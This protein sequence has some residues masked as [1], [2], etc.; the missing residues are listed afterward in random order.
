MK[1]TARDRSADG[2]K[3]VERIELDERAT[4]RWVVI[5]IL[6]VVTALV[7]FGYVIV[8]RATVNSGWRDIEVNST[9]TNCG[10]DFVLTYHLG[11]SGISASRESKALTILYSDACEKAYR[12]FN[13]RE[14][15]EDTANL[16]TINYN[17]NRPVE[18]DPALYAAF[19]LTERLDSRYVYLAP[20]YDEYHSLFFCNDDWETVAYDPWQSD[21]AAEYCAAVAAFARDPEQVHVRLLGD[22]T[23]QLCVSDEY[24]AFAEEY[25]I[26]RFVDFY[27][28]TDAFII[29]YL[30]QALRDGGYTLGALSGHDG[31]VRCLGGE[32][33]SF[34][35]FVHDPQPGGGIASV[36]RMDY[37][38]DTALVNLHSFP[39]N[40]LKEIY[41]YQFEDGTFRTAI[42]DIADGRSKGVVPS[43]IATSDSVG[44]AELLLSL[45]PLYATDALDEAALA[46]LPSRGV[47]PLYC[48]AGDIVST[49]PSV[50]LSAV[51]EGYRVR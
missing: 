29:D 10:Q 6:A 40:T 24:L 22:N 2:P 51:A 30:A 19:E 14:W 27:W 16:Y 46:E 43:M 4:R 48:Q 13:S 49:D 3:A 21:D 17:V 31:F 7:S 37:P 36:A 34:S 33:M 1:R 9:E 12:M 25:G 38:G 32:D 8:Q 45:L 18:V 35:Y 50:T 26:E 42:A 5:L 11:S 28:M 44:C 20:V 15:F 41:Y 23:V 47:Y 39:L